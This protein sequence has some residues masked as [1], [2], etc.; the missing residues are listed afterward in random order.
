MLGRGEC[1]PCSFQVCVEAAETGAQRGIRV[2]ESLRCAV[3]SSLYLLQRGLSALPAVQGL[4]HRTDNATRMV[5]HLSI[6]AGA[7]KS[8][9]LRRESRIAALRIRRKGVGPCLVIHRVAIQ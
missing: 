1:E 2:V 3:R 8:V 4:E 9:R 6:V 5:I 7:S